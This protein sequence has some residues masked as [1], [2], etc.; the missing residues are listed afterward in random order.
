M[1][2]AWGPAEEEK[3]KAPIRAQYETQGHPYYASARLWDDGVLDPVD[4]RMALALGDLRQPEC[5]DRADHGSAS[6]ACD[7][8]SRAVFGK[9]LIANRGEIACR[10]IRTA[11]QMGIATVAVYAE[12]DRDALHVELADMAW[13]LVGPAGTS[14]SAREGYLNIG[15]ILDAARA[16]G[17]EAVHPGY[18]F[19]S[20]NPDFA[21]ACEKAGLVFIGPPAA[22]IRALG[23]KAAAKTLMER[24]GVPVVPGYHGADQDPERLAAEA[25]RIGFPVL[26][27]ASAGGGG[28]GMRVVARRPDFCRRSPPRSAKPPA[29]LA[30]TG[31]WSRNICS[32]RVISRCRSSPIGTAMRSTCST[33]TARSSA[34]IRRSSKRRRRPGSTPDRRQAMGEAAVA[35]ARAAGYVGAGTVEFIADGEAFYFIEVNTRL[36]VEHTVTE[37]V[38]GLDLVEWQLRV[39]AGE[40]IAVA[41]AG[42]GCVRARGRGAALRRRSRSAIFCRRPGCCI[43]C[44]CRRPRSPGSIPG[45]G[46]AIG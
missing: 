42:T 16:S 35:A 5:A 36:Q 6:S 19:L 28:R 31:C 1:A 21:E 10:V 40:T 23:S 26:I 27:K 3:F 38:T 20:E 2:T 44:A 33:A 9:I 30:T 11:R 14:A 17:A 46:K 32:G 12:G 24:A 13:P 29:P 8:W 41:P 4:T 34:A 18:G 25:R 45:C 37:A 15:A 43:G 39:A 22:A 7:R